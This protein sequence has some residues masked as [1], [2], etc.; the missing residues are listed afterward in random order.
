MAVKKPVNFTST[1]VLILSPIIIPL[2]AKIQ[3]KTKR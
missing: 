2:E 1:F 3:N